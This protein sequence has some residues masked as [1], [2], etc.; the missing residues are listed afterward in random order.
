MN[1]NSLP[2]HPARYFRALLLLAA[3]AAPT[4]AMTTSDAAGVYEGRFVKGSGSAVYSVKNNQRRWVT[5]Q[6]CYFAMIGRQDW[7]DVSN[8]K[9]KLLNAVPEAAPLVCDGAFVKFHHSPAVYLVNGNTLRPLDNPTCAFANGVKTDWSNVITLDGKWA[10]DYGYGKSVCRTTT[11]PDAGRFIKGSSAAVYS[12]RDNL[13]RWITGAGCYFQIA[14]TNDWSDVENVSDSALASIP[15]SAPLYCNHSFV[16]FNDSP[17]VYM[18]TGNTLRHLDDPTCAFAN[19]VKTD[20]S[21]VITLDGKWANQ[22]GY[23][24]SVCRAK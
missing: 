22:F 8:M 15:E 13:R 3:I 14:G 5:S 9:D 18:T 17:A 23:G 16:K 12:A 2:K 10:S 4:F 7:S 24:K 1:G 19:G 21:N 6:S 11:S 20:W